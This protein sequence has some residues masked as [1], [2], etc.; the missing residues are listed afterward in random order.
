MS[1]NPVQQIAR[2]IFAMAKRTE[3]KVTMESLANECYQRTFT[4]AYDPPRMPGR[5]K[6]V[7]DEQKKSWELL[8]GYKE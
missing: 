1:E 8:A 4:D 3:K 5:F 2:T 7:D 6:P